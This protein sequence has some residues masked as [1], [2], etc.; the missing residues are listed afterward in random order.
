MNVAI[1]GGQLLLAPVV[2]LAALPA[3]IELPAG[4]ALTNVQLSQEVCAHALKFVAPVFAEVTRTEGQFSVTMQGGRL[5]LADPTSGDVA[6]Q[7]LVRSVEMRPGPIMQT[8][9]GFAQQVEGIL[10]GKLPF[11][12]AS[13]AVALV[14]IDNQTVDFRLVDRRVYHRG[15]QFVAGNVTI[16]THGS[17]GLDETI[18]VLAEIPMPAGLLANHPNGANLES[19]TLKIPI[20]GT[21]KNPKMDPKAIEQLPLLL[22]K[23]TGS[24]IKGLEGTLE[25]LVPGER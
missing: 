5:P 7:L 21:L 22:L 10:Q 20:T 16:T 4:P 1:A 2:R 11:A 23:G 6:G 15:L 12:N 13:Q 19:Q 8:L 14:R 17:V 3:E 9:V 25:K 18:A 24:I